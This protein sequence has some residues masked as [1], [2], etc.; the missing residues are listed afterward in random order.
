MVKGVGPKAYGGILEQVAQF[1]GSSVPEPSEIAGMLLLAA[2][3]AYGVWR[4]R[5]RQQFHALLYATAASAWLAA[6]STES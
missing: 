6:C 2:M 4:W 3:G 1:S 5:R